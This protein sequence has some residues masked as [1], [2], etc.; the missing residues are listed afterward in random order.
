MIPLI[1]NTPESMVKVRVVT[2]KDY[3]EQTLKA[4]HRLGVLHV[5]EGKELK[6]VDKAAIERERREVSQLLTYVE[7]ILAFLPKEG[8]VILTEDI[9]VVYTRPFS[10]LDNEI[11]ALHT[12]LTKLSQRTSGLTEEVNHLKELRRYLEPLAGQADLKLKDLKFSGGYLF[13]RVFVFSNES[14]ETLGDK[15]KSYV[16]ESIVATID[17]ETVFYAI[18]KVEDQKVIESVVT[19]AGGKILQVSDE[20]LTLKEFFNVAGDRI[21]ILEEE[22][23]N[24]YGELQSKAKENLER[25]VL[26]REALSAENQRLSA[27]GKACETKYVTLIE[28]WIPEKDAETAM[29]ELRDTVGYVFSDIRKPEPGEEPPTKLKNSGG[30]KP[31][32]LLVNNFEVPK[33]RGWDPTP[34]VAY[35]FSLF[36]GIMMSDVIY[37]FGLLAAAKF[38]LPKFT[39]DPQSDGFKLFQRLIYTCGVV[40]MV[41]GLLNGNYMGDVHKLFG[42]GDL[43]LVPA[44]AKLMG[45]PMSFIILTILIGFVHVNIGHLLGLIKGVKEKNKGVILGRIGFFLLQLGIPNMLRFLLRVELPLITDQMYT[46]LL[47][48]VSASVILIIVSEIMQNGGL[49]AFLWLFD[50]TGLFGDIISYCRLAGVG[51][52]SFYL[53]QSFNMLVGLFGKFFPGVIGAVIGTAI[54]IGFFIFGHTIN[55]LLGGLG[56]FVHSMRLCYVEFMS[57]FYE[58]GGREY[59]PFKLRKRATALISTRSQ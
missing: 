38:L 32:E 46:I 14:Y 22:L 8:S 18:G 21:R 34:I 9:E 50:I 45:D 41:I 56:C 7:D 51:L 48:I 15:L 26:L 19:D 16:S 23:A 10:E 57:K 43:A 3:S 59:S 28:G 2:T 53:G 37:G 35:S 54:G 11:K 33:Y 42:L 30:F 39:D 52:A 49:G 58:G 44:L 5:E 47:Y 12:K 27:L 17:N 29:S 1:I 40:A 55:I 31:F 6:P 20:D 36:F 4:L 25:L 13:S 24:L